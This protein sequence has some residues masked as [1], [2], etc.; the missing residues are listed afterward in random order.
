V[1]A[2]GARYVDNESQDVFQ[3]TVSE[4]DIDWLLCVELNSSEHFRQWMGSLLFPGVS[5]FEHIGAWR[6]IN[7][8]L[9]ESDLI[10]MVEHAK[11]GRL[12]ALIEN[13]ISAASQPN[14]YNRYVQRGESYVNEGLAQSYSLALLSPELYRSND[15]HLYP[16]RITYEEIAKWLSCIND[17]RSNY[18]KRIYSIAINKKKLTIFDEEMSQFREHIWGLVAREFPSLQIPGRKPTGGGEYWI[19]MRHP[20]YTLIYSTL[21]IFAP[22]RRAERCPNR[23]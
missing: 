18:L 5:D 14:Q 1:Q 17:E 21:A 23:W 11:E 9:G 10:W 4:A 7:N 8:F 3:Q 22:W 20:R 16:I 13:K 19:Y 15:D 12:I 6:S 2:K